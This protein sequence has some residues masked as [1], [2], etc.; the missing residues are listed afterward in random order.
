MRRSLR[1]SRRNWCRWAKNA[2]PSTNTST[3]G[4]RASS[5]A[6]PTGARLRRFWL[7]PLLIDEESLDVSQLLKD[8]A[9]AGYDCTR[10]RCAARLGGVIFFFGAQGA[11]QMVAISPPQLSPSDAREGRLTPIK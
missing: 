8:M 6:F 1:A 2:L 3:R 5:V 4:A 7:L 11:S 10:V 9:S